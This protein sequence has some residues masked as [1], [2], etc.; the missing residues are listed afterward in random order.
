MIAVREL[1]AA[2]DSYRQLGFTVSAGGRHTHAP[3]QNALIYFSDGSYLELIE[4][5][6]PDRGDKWYES[7]E[8]WGEGLV[9]FALVPSALDA[10][11]RAASASHV[12]YSQPVNGSRVRPDGTEA[13]WRLAWPSSAALPFLCSDV[14]ERTLR[15]PEGPV[16]IHANGA[17]GVARISVCVRDLDRSAREYEA[18]LGMESHT[19]DQATRRNH[20]RGVNVLSIPVGS[21][22]LD[23]VSPTADGDAPEAERLWRQLDRRGEGPTGLMLRSN[24]EL[25]A[26]SLGLARCHGV[27]LWL[28][29]NEQG[30]SNRTSQAIGSKSS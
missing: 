14:T 18:L 13:R 21:F 4:W 2:A 19:L 22:W 30:G 7:L 15:V 3:T 12:D 1:A 26:R 9:D 17:V 11:L 6:E 10:T 24:R 16:R 8:R 23:L 29:P 20:R 5:L 27:R 28:V 25:Q